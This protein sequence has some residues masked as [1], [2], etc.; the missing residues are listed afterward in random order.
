MANEVNFRYVSY[1]SRDEN[2]SQVHVR[3]VNAALYLKFTQIN[4]RNQPWFNAIEAGDTIF[5]FQLQG[6]EYIEVATAAI[7]DPYNSENGFRIEASPSPAL[8]EGQYYA[9]TFD[10]DPPAFSTPETSNTNG[11][12]QLILPVMRGDDMVFQIVDWIGGQGTKPQLG[13]Q[14]DT[15][16]V[17]DIANARAWLDVTTLV[18]PPGTTWT[19]GDEFPAE[20]NP[21]DQHMFSEAAT[22]TALDTDGTTPIT[23]AIAADIFNYNGTAWVKA[24]NLLDSLGT[25][26]EA[27]QAEI[28]RIDEDLSRE[29]PLL[30]DMKL[31]TPPLWVRATD[32]VMAVFDNS[33]GVDAAAINAYTG[34]STNITIPDFPSVAIV[35]RIPED[36]HVGDYRIRADSTGANINLNGTIPITHA[37]LTGYDYYPSVIGTQGHGRSPG[38]TMTLQHHSTDTHTRYLGAL[39]REQIIEAIRELLL[40]DAST[41]A[42]GQVAVINSDVDGWILANQTGGSGGITPQLQQTI[43]NLVEKTL[44]LVITERPDWVLADPAKAQFTSIA[45]GS[46]AAQHL[47]NRQ[48]PT[49]ATGWTND[50]TLTSTRVLVVRIKATENLSDYRFLFDQPAGV[51]LNF[52]ALT[53]YASDTDWVYYGENTLTNESTGRIRLQFHGVDVSSRYIG[54]LTFEKVADALGDALLL[55][56]PRRVDTMPTLLEGEV[57]FLTQNTTVGGTNY[58]KGTYQGVDNSGTIVPTQVLVPNQSVLIDALAR[59]LPTFPAEGSRDNKVAK[60]NENRLEWIVDTGTS[61]FENVEWFIDVQPNYILKPA[62]RGVFTVF[63]HDIATDEAGFEDVRRIA[64]KISGIAVH[65]EAWRTSD[66]KRVITFEVDATEAA[67]LVN[68]RASATS[69]DVEVFFQNASNTDLFDRSFTIVATTTDP[70]APVPSN[71]SYAIYSI[72]ANKSITPNLSSFTFATTLKRSN[73]ITGVMSL[74]NDRLAIVLK[75]GTYVI[76]THIVMD[77]TSN[78]AS[79]NRA[80]FE[81]Q[82]WDGNAEIDSLDNVGYLRNIVGIP[83]V[84]SFQTHHTITLGADTN[85]SVRIKRY[86]NTAQLTSLQTVAGGTVTVR[87]L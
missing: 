86:S 58:R 55:M 70:N 44:D 77:D 40:P 32:A 2:L 60:F 46:T 6:G 68:N 84:E 75:P 50:V 73:N 12:S 85:V 51:T 13:Y 15:G 59:L 79:D 9:V 64:I 4:P 33:A 87:K 49:G 65:V 3:T 80:N 57:V 39:V 11:W 76:D 1:D 24:F 29:N 10:R 63:L 52:S 67:N 61:V 27:L 37:T 81:V 16:I 54:D 5:F 19:V 22:I 20:P 38:D 41:G 7:L 53:Q 69:L 26:T 34:W 71:P 43:D 42:A 47:S 48:A 56:T 62:F 28:D 66:S 8:N 82:L 31:E 30:A 45:R 21:H 72:D 18:G 25:S 23:A 14:G 35:V 17:A 78:N 83:D 74:R 36:A